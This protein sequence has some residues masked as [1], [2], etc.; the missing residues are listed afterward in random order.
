MRYNEHTYTLKNDLNYFKSKEM[1]NKFI[2][3]QLLTSMDRMIG[4]TWKKSILFFVC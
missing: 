2:V 1:I 4:I 3:L